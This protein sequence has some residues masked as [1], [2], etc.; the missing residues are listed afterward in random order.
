MRKAASTG[1]AAQPGTPFD[2]AYKMPAKLST[3]QPISSATRKLP[4]DLTIGLI[5]AFMLAAPL[6]S[7]R[8]SGGAAAQPGEAR[9][10]SRK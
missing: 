6:V 4:G 1:N 8:G 7:V 10:P 2:R 5:L 9:G 3:P